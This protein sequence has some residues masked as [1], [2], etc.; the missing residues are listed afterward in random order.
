MTRENVIDT[1][2][3]AS[4]RGETYFSSAAVLKPYYKFITAP[5]LKEQL[6]TT[7]LFDW[8]VITLGS[9]TPIP[10]I[11]SSRREKALMVGLLVLAAIQIF[12]SLIDLNNISSLI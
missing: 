11:E 7:M 4:V 1:F 9:P 3:A 5:N 6:R 8:M 12:C 2:H 10:M